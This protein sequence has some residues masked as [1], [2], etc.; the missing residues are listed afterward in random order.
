MFICL[1]QGH[2]RCRW[3]CFFS[4]TQANIFNS[5][6]CK[7][8]QSVSHIMSVNG[9]HGFER[10]ENI[11]RQ[12]Q[13]KPCSSWRYTEVLRHETI[14]LCKKLNSIY[15]VFYLWSTA[16]SNCPERVHNSQASSSSS[17]FTVDRRLISALPPPISQMDHWHSTISIRSVNGPFER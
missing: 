15:I 4:R 7:P 1:P 17:C 9:T 13:I 3:L 16:L 6:C 8:L 11:H 5:N 14:G 10:K 2:P 12:N